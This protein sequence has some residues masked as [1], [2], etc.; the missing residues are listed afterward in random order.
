MCHL[1]M[2]KSESDTDIEMGIFLTFFMIMIFV[3][4]HYCF[5]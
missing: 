2:L 5:S 3:A 1:N 4:S